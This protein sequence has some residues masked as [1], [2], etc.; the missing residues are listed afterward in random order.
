MLTQ[1]SLQYINIFSIIHELL[2]FR[3]C[4]Q[5]TCYGGHVMSNTDFKDLYCPAKKEASQ[6]GYQWIR[7]DW[8]HNR[9]CFVCTLKGLLSRAFSFKNRLHHLGPKKGGVFFMWSA[10]QKTQRAL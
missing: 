5:N 2:S 7:L 3:L 6:E 10:L 9:R 1:I 4:D 8:V